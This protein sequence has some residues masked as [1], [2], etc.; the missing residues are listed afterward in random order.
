[1]IKKISSLLWLSSLLYSAGINYAV[2]NKHSFVLPKNTLEIK[3]DYQKVNDTIDVLNLKEDQFKSLGSIGN[4][5]GYSLE[6]RYGL[7]SKD[8]IF[9][10]AQRWNIDYGD[11]ILKNDRYNIFNRYL[12]LHKPYGFLNNIS[13]DIG[14]S[15][16]SSSDIVISN[17]NSLNALLRKI[18]PNTNIKLK[19]GDIVSGDTTITL[20]DKN[21]N[22]IYPSV[23]LNDLKSNSYYGRLL[24]GKT[25]S[26]SSILDFY[27]GFKYTKI[28]TKVSIQPSTLTKYYNIPTPDLNRDEENINVGLSYLFQA[29]RFIYEFNYEYNKMFRDSDVSY[30]DYNHIVDASIAMNITKNSLIYIG[31]RLMM[32]QFNTDIPYLY[33]KYTKTQFDHKY[34]FAKIGFIYRFK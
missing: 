4:M 27:V 29:G 33:N 3:A 17:D 24:F 21:G 7:S 13:F 8:S 2:S 10:S 16:N 19:D 15:Q 22:K 28:T 32:E 11:S 23:S 25:F 20:K 30:I 12:L 1:L 34:G 6:L 18:K 5:D 31:G 14:F 9:I 26:A